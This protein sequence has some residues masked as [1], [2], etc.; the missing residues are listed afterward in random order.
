MNCPDVEAPA[1]LVT[2]NRFVADK[3]ILFAQGKASVSKDQLITV[4]DAAEFAKETSQGLVVTG[5]AAKNE[6]RYKALAEQRAK[7]VA[8][9]L[10]EKY[11]VSPDKITVEWKEA[12]DAPYGTA[13]QGWNRVVII[14]SK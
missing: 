13:Q 12:G 1:P 11:G 9:L 14:R 7:A 6:N 3:S 2:E 10:T 4:F 5:Y 8:T